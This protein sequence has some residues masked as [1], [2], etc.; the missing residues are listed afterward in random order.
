VVK[1]CDTIDSVA[2]GVIE[3]PT[4]C[5]FDVNRL[6]CKPSQDPVFDNST[7]CLTSAQVKNV[8]QFYA[9]PGEKVY[10]GFAKGGESEW[11]PQETS[12][13]LEYGVPILQNLVFKNLS[14]DYNTFS[15]GSDVRVVDK[16]ATP[17]ISATSPDLSAFKYRGGKLI[18]FQGTS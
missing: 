14:Y 1:A 7:V 18:T 15:F 10:P 2:D 11:M 13:Y 3:D 4:K 6:E 9:G 17:L 12:L 8:Q 16:T 5:R